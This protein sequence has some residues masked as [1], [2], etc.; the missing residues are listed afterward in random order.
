MALRVLSDSREKT[1][2]KRGDLVGLLIQGEMT[3]LRNV[4]FSVWKI[5][6]ISRNRSHEE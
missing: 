5:T 3:S 1:A 6:A 2:D 4:N